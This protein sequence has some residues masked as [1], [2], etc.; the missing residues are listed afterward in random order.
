MIVF[1]HGTDALKLQKK[2]HTIIQSLRNKKPNVSV[3][4]FNA[5]VDSSMLESTL[6]SVG[7][8]EDNYI[9][10]IK[11]ITEK[12]EIWKKV[13]TLLQEMQESSHVYVWVEITKETAAIKKIK[14]HAQKIENHNT[15]EMDTP[16]EGVFDFLKIFF[17]KDAKG[18]WLWYTTHTNVDMVQLLNIIMWQ[19]KSVSLAAKAKNHTESGLKPYVFNTSKNILKEWTPED[20]ATLYT[21]CLLWHAQS[22]Q[23]EK[24]VQQFEAYI[25]T[26]GEKR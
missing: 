10:S 17:A 18:A 23:G 20:L 5:D 22:R 1:L 25:L 4:A 24:V 7:L 26:L 21:Q 13:S 14:K 12:K 15:Q 9:V 11:N 19:I 8:F 3:V 16:R 2:A 6:T